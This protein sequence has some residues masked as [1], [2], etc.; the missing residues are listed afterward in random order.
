M[1]EESKLYV[2]KFKCTGANKDPNAQSMLQMLAELDN[3]E[4][5]KVDVKCVDAKE[6]SFVAFHNGTRQRIGYVV[7]EAV[8]D[9]HTALKNDQI[10]KISFDCVKY[11]IKWVLSGPGYYTAVNTTKVGKW[12]PVVHKSA[13]Q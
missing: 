11:R 6:I 10:E 5:R 7:R 2:V 8:D 13:S 12:S 4:L 3:D 9:V 1:D